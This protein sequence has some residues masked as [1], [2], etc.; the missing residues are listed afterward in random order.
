MVV[1]A[2]KPATRVTA[3]SKHFGTVSCAVTFCDM[4]AGRAPQRPLNQLRPWV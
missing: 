3:V 4:Q 1:P 2:Q